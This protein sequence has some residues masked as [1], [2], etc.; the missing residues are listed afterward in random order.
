V[1]DSGAGASPRIQVVT[2][3]AVSLTGNSV[4]FRLQGKAGERVAF[5]VDRR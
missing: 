3:D 4:T 5:T 1:S 2:G